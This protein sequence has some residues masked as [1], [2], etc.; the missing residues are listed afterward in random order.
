MILL[1]YIVLYDN[2][3]GV[4]RIGTEGPGV[5][6][7][8]KTV[9][10]R[11]CAP[12]TCGRDARAPD[13][14]VA[15]SL[16][17]GETPAHP[18]RTW[19]NHFAF[20]YRGGRSPS[21]FHVQPSTRNLPRATFHVQP[22]TRNP[23]RTTLNAQPST[24]NPQRATLNVQPSTRNLQRATF[25]VQPSTCNLQRATFHAQ[26]STRNLQRAT[27]NVQPS[28]RNLQLSTAIS[29]RNASDQRHP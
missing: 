25:N 26:P 17:P 21:A 24:R 22:S 20:R 1:P 8:C 7:T 6:A 12:Y 19:L 11:N 2:T 5:T 27:F 16:G 15:Q 18:A 9:D 23:Q 14:H 29:G 4:T 3:R 10:R 13:T 28:T